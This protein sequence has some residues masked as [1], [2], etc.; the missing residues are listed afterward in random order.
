MRKFIRYPV[1]PRERCKSKYQ[2][3]AFPNGQNPWAIFATIHFPH[4]L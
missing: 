3:E 1:V 2:E 4:D